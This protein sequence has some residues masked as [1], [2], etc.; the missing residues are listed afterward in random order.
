MYLI[1]REGIREKECIKGQ[2]GGLDRYRRANDECP[3]CLNVL[4]Y[5]AG[6]RRSIIKP[7]LRKAF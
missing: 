1:K 6:Q 5:I 7:R 2:G 3:K 4:E